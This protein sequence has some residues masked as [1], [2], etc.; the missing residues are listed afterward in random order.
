MREQE[1]QKLETQ[2]KELRRTLRSLQSLIKQAEE[3]LEEAKKEAASIIE[4]AKAKAN[5][6]LEKINIR[7]GLIP[8]KDLED[9]RLEL[10]GYYRACEPYLTNDMRIRFF[11]TVGEEASSI[12]DAMRMR[13]ISFGG[14]HPGKMLEYRLIPLMTCSVKIG[15]ELSA[16]ALTRGLGAD[17]KRT[18]ICKIGF[19]FVDYIVLLGCIITLAY[20]LL[21]KI[22]GF[23]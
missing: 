18:N 11:P 12:S 16:A 5:E 21:V 7:L 10:V 19:R 20:L 9:K 14:N 17:V 6:W 4:S 3:K 2:E 13:G 8:K 1:I 23:L 15:D 22:G